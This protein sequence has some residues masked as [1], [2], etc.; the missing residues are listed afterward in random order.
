MGKLNGTR[1]DRA[2][3]L[4]FGKQVEYFFLLGGPLTFKGQAVVAGSFAANGLSNTGGEAFVAALDCDHLCPGDGLHHA[5]VH[6]RQKDGCGQGQNGD[7]SIQGNHPS[8]KYDAFASADT[9][10]SRGIS[11]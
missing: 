10:N 11:F 9:V 6:V 5:P 4:R 8:S 1:V 3:H 2:E 7:K